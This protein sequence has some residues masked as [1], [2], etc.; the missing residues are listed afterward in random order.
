MTTQDQNAKLLAE[1]VIAIDIET[2]NTGADIDLDNKRIISLQIGNATNV[3]LYYA[4]SKHPAYGLPSARDRIAEMLSNGYVFTG[5]Y[6]EDF[7]IRNISKFLGISIP[8]SNFIDLAR[9]DIINSLKRSHRLY[10]LEDVCSRYSIPVKHKHRMNEK[11]ETYKTR[12]DILALADREAPKIARKKGGTVEYARAEAIRKIAG[13]I[14]ILDSYKEFIEKGGS[15]DTLFYEYATGDVVC[16]YLLF[17][18][19]KQLQCQKP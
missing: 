12:Q 11:T 16:E 2:E 7:D 1:N 19:V 18:V 15:K 9:T 8:P 4:D 6:I 17:E 3:E 5:Y 14:A 13:G 10:K